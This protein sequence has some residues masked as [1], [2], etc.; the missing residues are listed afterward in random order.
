MVLFVPRTHIG[1]PLART[2]PEIPYSNQIVNCRGEV[3]DPVDSLLTT[4]LRLA[5]QPN[6]LH[7]TKELLDQLAFGLADSISGMSC[8]STV[9]RTA[10]ARIIL[11]HVRGDA[12]APEFVNKIVG[13]IILIAGNG[14]SLST[15]LTTCPKV[16]QR[17]LTLG[18]SA[19]LGHTS[20]G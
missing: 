16:L 7:P 19:G 20:F 15:T 13:I 17:G 10:P 9:N 3:E 18:G 2:P 8:G 12:Q 1:R 4:M 6:R 5:H 11:C 14:H